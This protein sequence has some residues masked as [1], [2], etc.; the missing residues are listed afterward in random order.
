LPL[1]F[2]PTIAPYS[3][4]NRSYQKD[5]R[6]KIRN[7]PKSSSLSYIGEGKHGAVKVLSL[8]F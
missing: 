5:K 8:C 1:Q 7:L 2:H 4:R 3:P 6:A